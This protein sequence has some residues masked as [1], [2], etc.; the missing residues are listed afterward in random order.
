ML[1]I[2]RVRSV[3]PVFVV[4]ALTL[5]VAA[6]G[7]DGNSQA[8]TP[9]ASRTIEVTANEYTFNGDPGTIRAGDTIDFA[10]RNTGMLDHSLEVLSTEGRSLGKTPRIPAGQSATVTV[11]FDAGG[12]YRLICD[13]DDHLSRG[14]SANITVT[15]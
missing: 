13:V 2:R 7:D 4:L 15:G 3:H 12:Q 11:T 8:A 1:G 14:Q 6:C 9:E 10:L 5:G